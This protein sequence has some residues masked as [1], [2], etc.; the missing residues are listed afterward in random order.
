M[1]TTVTKSKV[2]MLELVYPPISNQ[3]AV[4]LQ[5]DPEVEALLRQ[6]DFYMIGGRAEAKFS[7]SEVNTENETATFNFIVG[8]ALR[9][10]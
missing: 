8:I 5:N 1:A 9:T 3:E 6:S 2:S 4:W 7:P 10:L